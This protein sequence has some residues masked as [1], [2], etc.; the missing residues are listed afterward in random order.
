MSID[1]ELLELARAV[2]AYD[3]RL[4]LMSK[5][6]GRFWFRREIE[7]RRGAAAAR[8]AELEAEHGRSSDE[9]PAAA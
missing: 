1:T 2:E 5:D 9:P 8:L 3:T 4:Q 6:D 7:E